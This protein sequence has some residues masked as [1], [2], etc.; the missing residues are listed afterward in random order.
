M[1]SWLLL[2]IVVL[3][4][5]AQ[6]SK[7]CSGFLPENQMSIPA[8]FTSGI[9][10]SQFNNILRRIY[11]EYRIE[12]SA[13]G[14]EF[15]VENRWSDPTVNAFASK[16]GQFWIISM[17][18]GMAREPNMTYDG[19]AAIA[20]H[21]VGHH[22]GGA[23]L[24]GRDSDMAVEGQADYYATLKCLRRLF[25]GDDNGK[26]LAGRQVDATVVRNCQAEHRGRQDQLLCIRAAM[27]GVSLAAVMADIGSGAVPKITTPD[28]RRVSRTDET[29]PR[30]QCRLDTYF[31]GAL[32][33]VPY[34]QGLSMT[35]YRVGTC[36]DERTYTRGLRPRCWFAPPQ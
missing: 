9:T 6:A 11:N 2:F 28:K 32:C 25:R 36:A 14:A 18:G 10:E 4:P 15:V 26:I 3:G 12:F 5:Q 29:H 34:S 17:Y 22:L 33:R 16:N 19:F 13:Q 8:I 30:A 21:E 35:D 23:P 1:T 7:I 27:A 31:Q 20:C 24:Y